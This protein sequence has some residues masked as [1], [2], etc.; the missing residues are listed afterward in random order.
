MAQKNKKKSVPKRVV[1]EGKI[2]SI[3]CLL[4]LEN[5]KDGC[6]LIPVF[7]RL[8]TKREV[9]LEYSLLWPMFS[10]SWFLHK[11]TQSFHFL[12]CISVSL[13]LI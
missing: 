2:K 4:D 5:R 9:L 10:M 13:G 1:F 12:F 7:Y 3:Q 8:E 11:K 6:G